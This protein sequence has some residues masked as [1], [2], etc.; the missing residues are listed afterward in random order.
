MYRSFGDR[1]VVISRTLCFSLC[2]CLSLG[3]SKSWA[4]AAD[5]AGLARDIILLVKS[6]EQRIW[7]IDT[8]EI[9]E[10]MSQALLVVCTADAKTRSG[11]QA[12]VVRIEDEGGPAVEV[13]KKNGRDLSSVSSLLTLER[14][15]NLLNRAVS[16]SDKACPFYLTPTDPYHERHRPVRRSYLGFEG[17]GL[18]NLRRESEQVRVGGGGA[19]R[20]IYG[21]GWSPNWAIRMGIESGGAGFLHRDLQTE[22]ID[23]DVFWRTPR[24][25]T[26]RPILASR[27]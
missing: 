27:S 5:G 17:G 8:Y 11:A 24:L 18:F 20:L 12:I 10:L 21:Y 23:V 15:L 13:W 14:S 22:D 9:D 25:S 19:G 26:P 4:Q 16:R 2:F 6:A 7:S 1:V 3:G